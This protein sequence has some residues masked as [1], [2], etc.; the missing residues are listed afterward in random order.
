MLPP[1]FKRI[2]WKDD[3]NEANFAELFE[4][5]RGASDRQLDRMMRMMPIFPDAP[6][7]VVPADDVWVPD[8]RIAFA[9]EHELMASLHRLGEYYDDPVE[10]QD[11]EKQSKKEPKRPETPICKKCYTDTCGPDVTAYVVG[12]V[13]RTR[14]AFA[15]WKQGTLYDRRMADACCD[16]L[17]STDGAF[18]GDALGAVAWDI[19]RLFDSRW[20]KFYYRFD[21]AGRGCINTVQVARQC[22]YAG[23]VN[24]VLFGVMCRLCEFT[25]RKMLGHIW[26]YKGD[27]R[28]RWIAGGIPVGDPIVYPTDYGR[29]I[30]H[31]ASG[32]YDASVRWARVGYHGWPAQLT[33]DGDRPGCSP[34][35]VRG[36]PPSWVEGDFSFVV[37]WRYVGNDDKVARRK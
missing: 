9:N 11:H 37:R 25:E 33:P 15:G 29:K 28:P 2:A 17:T 7:F 16:A 30:A 18:S 10:D 19:Q 31:T 13:Q 22:H 4:F 24:Y 8:K 5:A 14:K 1:V 21:C 32:N 36:Y 26:M 12:A 6:E 27:T 34:A 23:S 3:R 35:C 20:L